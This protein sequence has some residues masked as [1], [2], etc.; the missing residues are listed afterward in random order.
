MRKPGCESNLL[1]IARRRKQLGELFGA[2]AVGDR[3][4][5]IAYLE[6]GHAA[7]YDDF[8]MANDGGDDALFGET[9]CP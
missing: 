2:F 8:A 6:R 7:R 9:G 4:H 3:Q 1:A 5:F